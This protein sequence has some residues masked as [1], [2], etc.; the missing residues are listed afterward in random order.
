MGSTCF[1]M[2]QHVSACFHYTADFESSDSG[3]SWPQVC[4]KTWPPTSSSFQNCAFGGHVQPENVVIFTDFEEWWHFT[5]QCGCFRNEIVRCCLVLDVY[6]HSIFYQI[7]H[8]YLI[9]FHPLFILFF[10]HFSWV[11]RYFRGTFARV[12][13]SPLP[14]EAA[15]Q[16]AWA[17]TLGERLVRGTEAGNG[18][19]TTYKNCDFRGRFILVLPTKVWF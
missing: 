2:F 3:S 13:G 5:P 14:Q 9:I 1:N 4:S 11:S 15:H 10:I 6:G 16:V 12:S 8:L 18:G 7:F 17:K 19:K